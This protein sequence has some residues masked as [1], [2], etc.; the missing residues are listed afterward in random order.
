MQGQIISN[1]SEQWRA[2]VNVGQSEG[3][4]IKLSLDSWH[5]DYREDREPKNHL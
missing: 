5:P 1:A 3:H 2:K 4:L